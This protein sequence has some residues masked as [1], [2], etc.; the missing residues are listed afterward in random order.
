[1]LKAET[2]RELVGDE[3]KARKRELAAEQAQLQSSEATVRWITALVKA[4][5]NGAEEEARLATPA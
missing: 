1:M 2:R 4:A 3:L 5:E